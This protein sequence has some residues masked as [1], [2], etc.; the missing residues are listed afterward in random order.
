MMSNP[1]YRLGDNR[2]LW[3]LGLIAHAEPPVPGWSKSRSKCFRDGLG[4]VHAVT[5]VDVDFQN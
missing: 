1:I 4:H 2:L 3:L 5:R